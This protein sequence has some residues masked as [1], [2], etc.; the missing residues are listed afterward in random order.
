ML[1]D[2]L[3]WLAFLKKGL[4]YSK[5]YRMICNQKGSDYE[6]LLKCTEVC[7]LFLGRA[8]KIAIKLKQELYAF[9]TQKKTSIP[10]LLSFL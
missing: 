5:P 1:R 3:M 10:N 7:W 4:K 6:N 9:L 8:L 2:A